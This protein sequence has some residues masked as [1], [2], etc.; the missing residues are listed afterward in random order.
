MPTIGF[1]AGVT[2]LSDEIGPKRLQMPHELLLTAASVAFLIN[3]TN[4]NAETQSREL[5]VVPRLLGL[6]LDVVHAGT[7]RDFDQRH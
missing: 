7:E 5:Q 1:L 2:T 4:P 3:P 6:R